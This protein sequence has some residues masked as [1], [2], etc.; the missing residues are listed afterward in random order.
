MLDEVVHHD[1]VQTQ[2]GHHHHQDW[3]VEVNHSPDP[4]FLN[5]SILYLIPQ[6]VAILYLNKAGGM[7]NVWPVVSVFHG[8][9]H[10]KK[11]QENRQNKWSS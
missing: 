1:Q 2:V 10:V 3:D 11:K 7:P 9:E 6:N 5:N 4:S 8:E